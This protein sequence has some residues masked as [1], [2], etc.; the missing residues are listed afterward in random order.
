MQRI[1]AKG[2]KH[3]G[4]KGMLMGCVLCLWCLSS[5]IP[6]TALPVPRTEGIAPEQAVED[7][8]VAD[9]TTVEWLEVCTNA[10]AARDDARAA[11]LQPGNTTTSHTYV[12]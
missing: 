2:S 12:L 5:I 8:S 10:C 11:A 7:G 6:S 1:M 4:S 3:G 9:N